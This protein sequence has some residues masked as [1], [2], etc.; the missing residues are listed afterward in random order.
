MTR[1]SN[2]RFA[3]CASLAFAA[4]ALVMPLKAD[5]QVIAGPWATP[6]QT[7]KINMD[8]PATCDD[9]THR[10]A[11]TWTNAGSRFAYT[12]GSFTYDKPTL[13][14]D[15]QITVYADRMPVADYAAVAYVGRPTGRT[16][17]DAD[18]AVNENFMFYTNKFYCGTSTTVSGQI[19]Y[20]TLILHEMGHTL[21][22]GDDQ[23]SANAWCATF[24]SVPEGRVVRSL[25]TAEKNAVIQ[26][27]GLR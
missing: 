25:C 15:S 9:P 1:I 22:L 27:Y 21:G 18:L 3:I 6:T 11:T 16:I 12:F 17:T 2:P 23:N 20:E 10:A 4:A 5:A 24:F 26:M 19:D 8:L 13:T 14:D 7:Y